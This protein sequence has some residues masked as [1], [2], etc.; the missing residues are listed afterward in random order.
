MLTRVADV[1]TNSYITLT[2]I[3]EHDK[4][5]SPG[6]RP[7]II[8]EKCCCERARATAA[9]LI[10]SPDKLG[11]M[12]KE[13]P[14]S[15]RPWSGPGTRQGN[16]PSPS[17]SAKGQAQPLTAQQLSVQRMRTAHQLAAGHSLLAFSSAE[18]Q[19]CLGSLCSLGCRVGVSREVHRES[20]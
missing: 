10:T 3:H 12:A 15:R 6:P 18:H 5:R 2:F 14:M 8:C 4:L 7:R 17:P 13:T 1:A 11:G 16:S 19:R 9:P 20:E